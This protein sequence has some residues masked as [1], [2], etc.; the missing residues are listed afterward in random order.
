LIGVADGLEE[1]VQHL[2]MTRIK[3]NRVGIIDQDDDYLNAD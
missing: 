1:M 3:Q 2:R